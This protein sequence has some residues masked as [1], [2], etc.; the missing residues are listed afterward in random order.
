MVAEAAFTLRAYLS[1][2][3]EQTDAFRLLRLC[4]PNAGGLAKDTPESQGL[5]RSGRA[6]GGAIGALR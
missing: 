1:D 4:L 2:G 5:I 3:S 6:D